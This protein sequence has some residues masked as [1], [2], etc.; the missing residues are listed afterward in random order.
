M[1][2]RLKWLVKVTVTALARKYVALVNLVNHFAPEDVK[3]VVAM[4]F[5]QVFFHLAVQIQQVISVALVIFPYWPVALMF[6]V[7]AA[8]M[9]G[10]AMRI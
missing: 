2:L 6:M 1:N 3:L 10:N 7:C 4:K 8:P 9:V 5:V